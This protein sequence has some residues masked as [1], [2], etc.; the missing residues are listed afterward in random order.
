M[1]AR[2]IDLLESGPK[3]VSPGVVR[4]NDIARAA[5]TLLE[6]PESTEPGFRPEVYFQDCLS[7]GA[8]GPTLFVF[9]NFETIENP[10]DVFRWIDTYIRLPN[11]VLITTR[12]RDF[13]GDKG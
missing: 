12:F 11:K 1:S 10:P 4:Q 2:D 9:D 7:N 8:A 13:A 3:P 5:V 6:P